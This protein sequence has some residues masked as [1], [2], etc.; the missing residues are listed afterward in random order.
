M[1]SCADLDLNKHLLV[2]VAGLLLSSGLWSSAV[3]AAT[4]AS[5]SRLRRDLQHQAHLFCAEQKDMRSLWQAGI[6][7]TLFSL[8]ILPRTGQAQQLAHTQAQRE[9]GAGYAYGNCKD[10]RSWVLSVSAP[11]AAML[12][13]R[14]IK[15][16][17]GL[18]HYCRAL[19]A[20][21]AP[22]GL[23]RTRVVTIERH[24]LLLPAQSNG[25]VAVNCLS[26]HP[27]RTGP[28]LLYAFPVGKPVLQA[29]LLP[30]KLKRGQERRAVQAWVTAL[31]AKMGLTALREQAI[32]P[33][34][35]RFSV[36][37]DRTELQAVKRTLLKQRLRL[38]G[39]NRARGHTLTEALTMLW[40]SPFHRDLLLHEAA[41][42]LMVDVVQQ[43]NQVLVTMLVNGEL[44][45]PKH[46]H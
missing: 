16:D 29:P 42:Y 41:T 39:E 34:P 3:Q 37:H 36:I 12:A 22:S 11:Y 43:R 18:Q 24:A 4:G 2:T 40:V 6:Y 23:Q 46:K 21:Y 30:Q 44:P 25:L 27:H 17:A 35:V 31:R 26:H 45:Q 14:K 19:R 13:G 33:P 15:L 1:I 8:R 5:A 9:G 38:L 32:P 10:D 7:D 28:R 20:R